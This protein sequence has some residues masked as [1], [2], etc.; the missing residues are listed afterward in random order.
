[1]LKSFR[2]FLAVQVGAGLTLAA[3]G[4][5]PAYAADADVVATVNGMEITEGD[6]AVAGEEYG[7]QFG[8][9]PEPQRRAALLS[10]LIEIRLLASQAEEKGLADSEAF[11]KRLEFLRQQALHAAFIEK[12]VDGAVTEEQVRASYDK[13]IAEAPAVNEVRARH[14]LVKTKEE[15]EAII[16]QLEEGGNFE[17]IAKEKSTDG[18]AANG[19]DLGYFTSG[20]MVPEFEKA[21]FA[22]NPGEHSKEPVETQFGF[23]VI[24]VED[25]RA[26]QPPAFDAVKDR[27]RSLLVREKYVEEVSALRDAAEVDVK[28]PALKEF[29]DGIEKQREGAASGNG[30]AAEPA[31]SE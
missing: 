2:R 8:N 12:V 30:D 19:G 9:L 22:L 6:L 23:H 4:F 17:E 10:A 21:A 29:I 18:A 15:A 11:A 14:I 25:K 31:K 26:K 20:Q 13:Q 16:K 24:K 27:V 3:V 28:D 7:A 1:M 5:M